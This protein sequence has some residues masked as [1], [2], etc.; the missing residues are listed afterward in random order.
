MC[1][2]YYVGHFLWV[3]MC[4]CIA[5]VCQLWQKCVRVR[6]V[7]WDKYWMAHG[8]ATRKNDTVIRVLGKD[9]WTSYFTKFWFSRRFGPQRSKFITCQFATHQ[10]HFLVI[11]RWLDWCIFDAVTIY[12]GI[13]PDFLPSCSPET[14]QLWVWHF[15]SLIIWTFFDQGNNL[16]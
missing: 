7:N 13:T 16:T 12:T 6:L 9:F 15:T 10:T 5:C 2:S 11:R 1:G 8:S 4:L 14:F 3:T